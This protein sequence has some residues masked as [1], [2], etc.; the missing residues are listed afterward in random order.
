MTPP[1][2][3][4]TPPRPATARPFRF[5]DFEKKKLASGLTV[6]A[7]RT[8]AVP[9]V[10]LELVAPAGGL[11]EGAGQTGLATFTAGLLDEGSERLGGALAIA[12][13]VDQLGGNLTTAA[14]RDV[15][16]AALSLL[17]RDTGEGLQ[18]IGELFSRPT[19]EESEIE[20]LRKLRKNELLRR[21]HSP[22]TLA[23]DHLQ[24]ALYAGT[25][26]AAPLAGLEGDV[27]AFDRTTILDFYRRHYTEAG[28]ALVAAGDLDPAAF[29]AEAETVLADLLPGP[30]PALPELV[31]PAREG[32]EV[33]LVDRPGAAQTELRL[34]HPG[35][36]RRHPDFSRLTV[37]NLLLGGKF[38][39][40]INMNLRERHGYTYGATSRFSARLGPGPFS[41][42]SAVANESAGAAAREVLKEIAHM[43]EERV[44]P[45]ELA[46]TQSYMLGV[47]SFTLQ[48]ASDLVQRLETLAVF[49][50]P[51]DHYA[52]YPERILSAT[53]EGLREAAGRHL[54]PERMVIVAVGPAEMLLPQFEGM[55]PVTVHPAG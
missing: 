35:P 3:R 14:D 51:D 49:D 41:V 47:F 52:R 53:P 33:H 17:S 29:V 28:A 19:F 22:G 40:R 6:Y 16:T 24:A 50:L 23:D 1:L 43:R 25:A 15:A 30:A 42:S 36:P 4:S 18:L 10:T 37:L 31:P 2:D 21:R 44:T 26:Y 48:T 45:Q 13:R 20:R 38:T 8:G 9:L 12:G 55:G 39:S 27:D 54:H 5:V 34:G 46:E 11:F 7:A 32:I